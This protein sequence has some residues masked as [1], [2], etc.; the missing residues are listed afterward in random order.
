MTKQ[1]PDVPGSLTDG[2][3]L[4]QCVATLWQKYWQATL[5]PS[6]GFTGWSLDDRDPHVIEQWMPLWEWLYQ[7]YFRVQAD[8]W[9]H[10]PATGQVM[11]IGSHNGGLAAPDTVMMTYDWLRRFGPERAAYGLMDPRIWQGALGTAQ[12]ATQI[13][14]VRAHPRMGIAA[15][16]RG[17]SVLIYPGGARDV[18][19]PHHQRHQVC[20]GD[21]QGFIKLA[22]RYEV[23]IIP[24]ISVGAHSTLVVLADLYPWMQQLHE[25]GL[26]W[27]LGIDPT[28]FPVYLGLPWGLAIGPWPNIPLPVPMQTRI[29]PPITFKHYGRAASRDRAY[30][31]ACHRQVQATMQVELDRLVQERQSWL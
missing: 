25:R 15:L 11:L 19:R 2:L 1:F 31:D 21:N 5:T 27:Y 6:P 18:F 8:G 23:P 24:A 20:L 4:G 13:G 17:A 14:A 7:H 16:E 28:V 29:C 9:E 3:A 10:V 30:V 26:P 22:L 12:L